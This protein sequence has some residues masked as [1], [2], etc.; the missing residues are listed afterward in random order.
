MNI[1]L[2]IIQGLLAL[3]FLL[4]GFMKA[5]TPLARLE[6]Y[7]DWVK[8]I[9]AALVRF[10]GIAEMLGAIGLIVPALTGI[11][12]WLTVAAA[13]GLALVMLAA[14][15]FHASRHELANIGLNIVL[16]ALALLI[17]VGRVTVAPAYF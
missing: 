6:Q 8:A 13:G 14:A 3:A 17:L 4:T 10:I 12:S 9:P 15:C 5:F 16:L 11:A 1:V 7:M 2:W